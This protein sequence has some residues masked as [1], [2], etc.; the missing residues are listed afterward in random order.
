[1][2]P[3]AKRS[4]GSI[5]RAAYSKGGLIRSVR[6]QS[7]SSSAKLQQEEEKE[8]EKIQQRLHQTKQQQQQLQQQE[9]QKDAIT[10]KNNTIDKINKDLITKKIV[11]KKGFNT[12]I[13][14]PSTLN[15]DT[16]TILLDKLYQGYNP[17]LSPI[18]PVKPKKKSSTILVNIYEDIASLNDIYNEEDF[19]NSE[20]AT[21]IDIGPKLKISK[22]I[23]DKNPEVEAKLKE[24]NLNNNNSNNS[25]NKLANLN[26]ENG[27]KVDK[28]FKMRSSSHGRYRLNYKK[29]LS[30]NKKDTEKSG[31]TGSSKNN[32]S[33]TD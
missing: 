28:L 15:L 17:L 23:F 18:T 26:N 19:A 16:K 32:S 33:K 12:V 24:L 29:N 31:K 13:K 21:E 9:L 8:Q 11:S 20:D 14:V 5:I 7:N 25:N 1:M 6:Y 10:G 27:K 22:Y 4:T 2:F 30:K 3:T